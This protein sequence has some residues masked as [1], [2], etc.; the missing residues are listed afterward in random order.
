MKQRRIKVLDFGLAKLTRLPPNFEETGMTDG[1][2]PGMVMGTVGY[3]SPEQ[4]RG[5]GVDGRTDIFAFGAILY[6]MLAGRRAFEKPTSA[7]TMAAILNEEPLSI[8]ELAP[9]TPPALVRIVKRCLEKDPE[10]RFQSAS[11]LAFALE[12]LPESSGAMTSAG[13]KHHPP[14]R[15]WAPAVLS[16]AVIIVALVLWKMVF[17][18]QRAPRVLNFAKLTNDSQPKFGPM[19]TDGSRIYF[20]E[21]IPGG[22]NVLIHQ[23][24]V[25]GGEVTTLPL[26]L[27]APEVLDLSR[28]ATELLVANYEVLGKGNSYWVEPVAGGAPR[29]VGTVRGQAGSFGADGTSLIYNKAT[30]YVVTTD[31]YSVSRDGSASRKLLATDG[32]ASG[33]RFSPDGSRLRFT[34]ENEVATT[35]TVMEAA[36]NGTGLIKVF[37]GCCGEWTPDGRFF[38]FQKSLDGRS[39]IWALPDRGRLWRTPSDRPTPLTAGPLDFQYPLP[40]KDGRQI[41]AIAT[42]QR[43]EVVRYDAQSGDFVPYLPGISAEALAFSPDGKWVTYTSYPEGTLWRSRV[44]GTERLQLTFPPM[45]AF[46]PRWSPDRKEIVFSAK[47]PDTVWNIYLISSEGGTPERLP[48]EH[49]QM[50]A[51]WSPDGNSLVF[52]IENDPSAPIYTMDLRTKRVSALPGSSGL[53]SSHWSPDGRFI[54]ALTGDSYALMIF[55]F[56]TQEWT[57]A[58]PSQVSF[59]TFSHDGKYIYFLNNPA[60]DL[61][62]R[63]LRLRMSDRKIEEVVDLQKAGPLLNGR[64]STW[65]GLAPDDSPLVTRDISTQEI[66]ALEMDWP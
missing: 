25:K 57:E 65:F 16:V 58:F 63:A 26:P 42:S 61:K 28:D 62:P 23:V 22:G 1:T 55:D 35:T 33:F 30:G 31:L 20:N 54:A 3:M 43:G 6:E 41:F 9:N 60:P 64:G 50:D 7:E 34:L 52:A 56:T 21:G 24:S 32:L 15:I 37:D 18:P 39:N 13:V 40:S 51:N 45:Q 14:G 38:T 48:S 5:Q 11:D 2:E 8:S 27:R 19:V 47:L 49:N 66:Y 59:E 17:R 53:Y 29:Q 12:A 10:Q 4:L 44:D 46:L 36:S